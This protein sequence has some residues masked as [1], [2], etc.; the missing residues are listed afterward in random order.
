[1]KN[2]FFKNALALSCKSNFFL[3]LNLSMKLLIENTLQ[4]VV[5]GSIPD[6]SYIAELVNQESQLSV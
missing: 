2:Y 5:K 1:M 3:S 6:W 4:L